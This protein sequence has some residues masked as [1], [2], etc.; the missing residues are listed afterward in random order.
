MI[1]LTLILF[2]QTPSVPLVTSDGVTRRKTMKN[3]HDIF[4]KGYLELVP[5]VPLRL[6]VLSV[7]LGVG[8]DEGKGKND[9]GEHD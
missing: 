7:Q 5:H 3:T 9:L 6:C 4:S 1:F 8:A 2:K